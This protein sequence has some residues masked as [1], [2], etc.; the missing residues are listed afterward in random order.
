MRARTRG[1]VLGAEIAEQP[2]VFRR[3]LASTRDQVERARALIAEREPRAV[4]FAAR[5]SSEHA[6][7][8]AKD[9]VE[10]LWGLPAG[11]VSPTSFTHYRA[12]PDLRDTLLV[13][14]NR[15]GTSAELLDVTEAAKACGALTVSVTNDIM[16]PLSRAAAA[17][18]EL[19]AGKAKTAAAPKLYSAELLVSYLLLAPGY[20]DL[21]MLPDLAAQAAQNTDELRPAVDLT[22]IART[23]I[24]V[25]RGWSTTTARQA[26][27]SLME[28][29]QVPALSFS[30][31]DLLQGP[32]GLVDRQ[33]PVLAIRSPGEV[34]KALDPLIAAVRERG[35]RVWS[36]GV[37]ADLGVAAGDLPDVVR[38]MLEIIPFQQ[39]ARLTAL[40]RGLDP[41]PPRPATKTSRLR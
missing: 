14:L 11:I 40:A 15:T 32:L 13:V 31:A 25:A 4:L 12:R 41:D 33:V 36:L 28:I 20:A 21:A 17:H 18:L 37:L 29:A 22:R 7:L 8:Y 38:P 19:L 2:Y 34:G 26:A 5:G 10:T 35:S 6:A 16:S 9:L 23:V 27:L 24:T 1:I 3:L 39:I 30:G